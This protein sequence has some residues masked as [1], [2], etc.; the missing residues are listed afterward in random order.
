MFKIVMKENGAPIA[1]EFE[2]EKEA[3]IFCEENGIDFDYWEI[4]EKSEGQ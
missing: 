3:K 4:V 1:E 2:T